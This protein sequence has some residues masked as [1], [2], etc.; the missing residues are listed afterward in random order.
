MKWL[1]KFAVK[2]RQNALR[3]WTT[4]H[5]PFDGLVVIALAAIATHSC[6]QTRFM[7]ALEMANLDAWVASEDPKPSRDIVLVDIDDKDYDQSF[8]QTSP[9]KADEVKKLVTA[10]VNA[11]AALVVVDLDT[12]AWTAADLPT[13]W[14]SRSASSKVIWARTTAGQ[15]PGLVLNNVAGWS[16]R[17][18]LPSEVCWGVPQVV[19][20]G[21]IVR[22]YPPR[23]PIPQATV[24]S[25]AAAATAVFARQTDGEEREYAPASRL[26]RNCEA[27]S[28]QFS[29]EPEAAILRSGRASFPMYHARDARTFAT[30]NEMRTPL[31]DKLV[32]LGGTYAQARDRYLTPAG[33]RFG[34]QIVATAI[35]S[36]LNR[37]IPLDASTSFFFTVDIVLGLILL[38]LGSILPRFSAMWVVMGG[39]PAAAFLG[40]FIVFRSAPAHFF[41]FLPVLLGVFFHKVIEEWRDGVGAGRKHERLRMEIV[42]LQKENSKLQFDLAALDDRRAT[43]SDVEMNDVLSRITVERA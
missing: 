9:L 35:Q 23:I 1:E 41:S 15:G 21:G 37:P 16:Q 38:A 12:S 18:D 42:I 14:L 34:I 40:S 8:K 29:G 5:F 13:T 32:V 3:L 25:L 17:P 36:E 39:I 7:H 19:L 43:L 6:E 30:W 2:I 11:G 22:A 24:P 4:R 28:F 10:V 31:T 20:S 27:L 33:D 26:V